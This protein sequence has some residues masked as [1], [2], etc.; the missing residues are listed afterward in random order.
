MLSN[1][2]EDAEEVLKLLKAYNVNT[3]V[4]IENKKMTYDELAENSVTIF[5]KLIQNNNL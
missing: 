2:L 5:K 1:K 4:I 3:F